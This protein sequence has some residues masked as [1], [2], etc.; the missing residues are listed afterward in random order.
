MKNRKLVH[1]QH[2]V[3]EFLKKFNKLYECKTSDL[4]GVMD[5]LEKLPKDL[6]HVKI[7]KVSVEAQT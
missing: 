4:G 7:V 3:S 1:L 6:K 2:E 5:R